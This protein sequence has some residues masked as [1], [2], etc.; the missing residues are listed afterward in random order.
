MKS[1]ALLLLANVD[2]DAKPKRATRIIDVGGI[3]S[4]LLPNSITII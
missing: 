2:S 3:E 4:A 1:C